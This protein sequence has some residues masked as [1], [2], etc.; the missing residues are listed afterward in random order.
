MSHESCCHR[1][2]GPQAGGET[3]HGQSKPRSGSDCE[4]DLQGPLKTACHTI[5]SHSIVV[6]V[7]ESLAAP[8]DSSDPTAGFVWPSAHMLAEFVDG[9]LGSTLAEKH[10]LEVCK[11]LV[12]Q[13]WA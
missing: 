10:V 13:A 12:S 1:D 5:L 7:H 6:D 8:T 3:A 9:K 2:A 4:H 11:S